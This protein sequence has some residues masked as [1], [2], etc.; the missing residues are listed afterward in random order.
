MALERAGGV[1]GNIGKQIAKW[2]AAGA[3][4][5]SVVPIVG[6]AIGAAVGG[7]VGM[8]GS[9]IKTLADKNI[10]SYWKDLI[11]KNNTGAAIGG[12]LFSVI[13]GVGTSIGMLLG[14]MAQNKI[15]KN[16]LSSKDKSGGIGG[17][18]GFFD[19]I[20]SSI[21]SVFRNVSNFFYDIWDKIKKFDYKGFALEIG[22]NVIDIIKNAWSSLKTFTK[23]KFSQLKDD[24]NNFNIKEFALD[25]KDSI[26]EFFKSMWEGFKEKLGK[27]RDLFKS[28]WDKANQALGNWAAVEQYG[29]AR[30]QEPEQELLL[31]KQDILERFK[32][33]GI[34]KYED[35][36]KIAREGKIPE[37]LKDKGEKILEILQKA[38]LTN[39]VLTKLRKS[40]ESIKKTTEETAKSMALTLWGKILDQLV[41][42]T[43]ITEK[44]PV[45]SLTN[46][47]QSAPPRTTLAEVARP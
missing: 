30:Y 45:A 32:E 9:I 33:I 16:L 41:D 31:F 8:W 29:I 7:G 11:N 23:D 25:V 15:K 18:L 13:P 35:I 1:A 17:K 36:S 39:D 47:T 46:Q 40:L 43:T 14:A 27:L 38:G 3:A 42:L 44:K 5:G 4:V 2:G 24:W 26:I 37:H 6:T 22:S 10:L 21:G 28:G 19:R 12:M 20:L 34:S